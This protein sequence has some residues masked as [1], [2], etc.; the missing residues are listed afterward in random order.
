MKK[1]LLFAAATLMMVGCSDDKS[2]ADGFE[3]IVVDSCEYL[4]KEVPT[5]CGPFAAMA[6]KGNCRFC[7]ER[8]KQ[9]LKELVKQLKK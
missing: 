4:Y 2:D 8:R 9:E 1:I 6:H 3:T 7:K 5:T